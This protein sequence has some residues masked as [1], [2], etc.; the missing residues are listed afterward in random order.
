MLILPL[1]N[2]LVDYAT[3]NKTKSQFLNQKTHNGDFK[4]ENHK[5]VGVLQKQQKKKPDLPTTTLN[6]TMENTKNPNSARFV[7]SLILLWFHYNTRLLPFSPFF[8][9]PFFLFPFFLSFPFL[10]FCWLC[11]K[12][13][14][15]SPFQFSRPHRLF[16][17]SFYKRSFN[18]K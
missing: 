5:T 17:T 13:T 11:A 2:D 10:R 4:K 12:K 14:Y 6:R 7:F 9:S 1:K 18:K 3:K 16:L 8:L 15:F